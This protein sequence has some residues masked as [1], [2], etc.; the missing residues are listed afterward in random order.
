MAHLKSLNQLKLKLGDLVKDTRVMGSIGV[1]ELNLK[2]E[3]GGN[4]SKNFST[5]CL[6]LDL[7]V[8]PLGNV[9]YLMPPYGTTPTEIAEA[10]SKIEKV[11]KAL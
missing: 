2:L 1:L 11:C 6:K 7:F 8:R 3:Y 4:F 9:I 10:W 5:E